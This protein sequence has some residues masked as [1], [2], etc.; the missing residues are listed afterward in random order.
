MQRF[1][2]GPKFYILFTLVTVFPASWVATLLKSS[3]EQSSFDFVKTLGNLGVI[4]APTTVA[5]IGLL[6]WLY[7][8]YL[9]RI[10][11]FQ[12]LH[13]VPDIAGRYEGEVESSFESGSKHRIAL[14]IQQTLLSVSVSLYTERSSSFSVIADVGKNQHGNPFLAYVYKNTPRTVSRDLDMRTH[15]GFASL[16]IFRAERRLDGFYYNDPRERPTHGKLSCTFV[17]RAR[18]GRF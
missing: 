14:E 9:W 3:I 12:Y 10:W 15:D 13:G 18:M 11:P 6:F 8:S 2:L 4:E 16:D 1:R 17:Q 5:L 7:Q